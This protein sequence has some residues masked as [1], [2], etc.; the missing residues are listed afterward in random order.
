MKKTGIKCTVFMLMLAMIISCVPIVSFAETENEK[1]GDNLTWVIDENKVLTISGTGEMYDYGTRNTAPWYDYE[2]SSIVINDGVTGIGEFAF[3][4][5]TEE[6]V[7][8]PNSVTVIGKRAFVSNNKLKSVKIP[9]SV[10][11]LENYVFDSCD[12]LESINVENGNKYYSSQDGVLFNKDKDCLIQ[13]PSGKTDEKYS[14]PE[15]VKT[16]KSGAF[17]AVDMLNLEIPSSVELIEGSNF[18]YCNDAISIRVAE[19]NKNYCADDSILFNKDKT[20]LVQYLPCKTDSEY[21]VPDSVTTIQ[22]RAFDECI[23]LKYIK[24]PENLTAIEFGAFMGCGNLKSI[25]IPSGVRTISESAFRRCFGLERVEIPDGVT[26]IGDGAFYFCDSIKAIELPAGLTEIGEMAFRHCD[27]LTDIYYTGTE[28]QWGNI[29]NKMEAYDL[30]GKTIHYNSVAIYPLNVLYEY[31][32]R[33]SAD[34]ARNGDSVTVTVKSKDTSTFYK[35]N[36]TVFVGEFDGKELK[37]IKELTAENTGNSGGTAVFTGDIS[38]NDYTVFIWK[39]VDGV[40]KPLTER[41]N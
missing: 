38:G 28:E 30:E 33:L 11:T 9:N 6:S 41:F 4:G 8:I 34:T 16:I 29:N 20:A 31:V 14:I 7:E 32:S 36:V 22:R 10:T 24:L 25:R 18:I 40:Y 13:Y 1:C 27:A 26:T 2:I 15:G 3:Y 39:N 37:S 21:V 17:Y 35:E 5:S 19:E 23:N 12:A